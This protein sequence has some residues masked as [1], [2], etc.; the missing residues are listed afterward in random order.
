MERF[1]TLV[2]KADSAM[3]LAKNNGNNAIQYYSV[4]MYERDVAKK[5]WIWRVN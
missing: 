1:E 2:K 3:Y 5:N 4:D